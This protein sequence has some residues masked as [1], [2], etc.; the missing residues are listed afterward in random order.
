MIE[1]VIWDNQAKTFHNE[2]F[3][4]KVLEFPGRGCFHCKVHRKSG[5]KAQNPAENE[6]Q[7]CECCSLLWF[8]G[9]RHVC[10]PPLGGAESYLKKCHPIKARKHAAK[11]KR[12]CAR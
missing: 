12:R 6:A 3:H 4:S 7:R 1:K 2:T 8:V 9:P 10:Q 5:K 11:A